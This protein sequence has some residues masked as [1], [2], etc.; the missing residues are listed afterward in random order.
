MP[1][2]T[3]YNILIFIWVIIEMAYFKLTCIPII[4]QNTRHC[5]VAKSKMLVLDPEML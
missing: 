3:T 4:F 2:G 5:K 1:S